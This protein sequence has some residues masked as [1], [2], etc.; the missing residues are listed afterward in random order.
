MENKEIIPSTRPP[1]SSSSTTTPPPP[2]SSSLSTRERRRALSDADIRSAPSTIRVRRQGS[3]SQI[4]GIGIKRR[5]SASKLISDKDGNIIPIRRNIDIN[6]SVIQALRR[7]SASSLSI[8]QL[9]TK[10][11]II[12][13]I[14]N[15]NDALEKLG[16]KGPAGAYSEHLWDFNKLST[17]YQCHIDSLNPSRSCGLTADQAIK[18]LNEYGHNVLTPPPRI[19]LW[20]L[21]LLQFTNLLIILIMI[22]ATVSLILYLTDFSLKSNLYI[23]KV[24]ITI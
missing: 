9:P 13:P 11:K 23:G 7:G 14:A 20:L 12:D 22:T 10:S 4:E 3:T 18:H 17:L 1:P 2:S 8:I 5:E 16:G 15:V 21:F 19:P 6:E 24:F